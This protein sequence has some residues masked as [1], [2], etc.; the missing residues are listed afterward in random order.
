MRTI[1]KDKRGDFT[2]MLYMVVMIAATAFFLILVGFIGS[3]IST[4]L[5]GQINASDTPEVNQSFQTTKN[6]SENTLSALWYVVF[7]GLLLGLLITSWYI[8]THPVMVAPFIVLLIIAVII[9]VAMSNAYEKLYDVPQL[10]DI[11]STQ[12]SIEFAMSN[13]PYLALV[14]GIIALI[15]TF[16]KPK[17]EGAAPTG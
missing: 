8:P 16:A 13:L 4:E 1:L 2:G 14:I 10:S 9:G 5:Q 12:G 7:G 6:I 11:A 3:E 17:G 15:V